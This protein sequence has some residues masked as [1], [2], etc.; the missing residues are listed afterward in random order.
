[1]R[2]RARQRT[3]PRGTTGAATTRERNPSVG[4][5]GGIRGTIKAIK[6]A[7]GYGFVTHSATGEDYFFHRSEVRDSEVPFDMLQPDDE[8]EFEPTDGPKGLR[9][10]AVRAL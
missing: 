8:V 10:L 4:P 5:N 3:I 2:E 1:M 7:E 9:A 6:K